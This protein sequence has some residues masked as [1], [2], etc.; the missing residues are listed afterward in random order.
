MNFGMMSVW[1]SFHF[2][3][4]LVLKIK[5]NGFNQFYSHVASKGPNKT[6]LVSRRLSGGK[7]SVKNNK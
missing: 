7:V 2:E 4:R 5:S 3:L 6:Y 1:H